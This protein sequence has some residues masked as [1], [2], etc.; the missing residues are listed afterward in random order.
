MIFVAF[1]FFVNKTHTTQMTIDDDDEES[2]VRMSFEQV[3]GLSEQQQRQQQQ[4][5]AHSPTLVSTLLT[6]KQRLHRFLEY[7]HSSWAATIWAYFVLTIILISVVF[8]I[9]ESFPQFYYLSLWW[10]AETVV[11]AFFTIEYALRLFASS[12]NIRDVWNFVRQPMNIIDFLSFAPFYV[13]ILFALASFALHITVNVPIFKVMRL[14]RVFRLVRIAQVQILL[15]AMRKSLDMLASVLFFICLNILIA[16]TL[17]YFAERGQ[18][19][20]QKKIFV[21]KDG[22]PT[23]FQSILISA[24]WSVVT[25]TTTGYGDMIPQT[26]IGKAIAG[27]SI[28]IGVLVIALPSLL[29]GSA[30]SELNNQY[31]LKKKRER[32][33]AEREALMNSNDELRI[34]QSQESELTKMLRKHNRVLKEQTQQMHRA[35][36]QAEATQKLIS[37]LLNKYVVD[38]NND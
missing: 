34:Q 22:Q 20:Y 8:M 3:L 23:Q 12:N 35:I 25:M 17:I 1:A 10:Y 4:Q 26:S 33:Q 14:F 31:K 32:K 19:D 6:F 21:G 13:E 29:I 2:E 11:V 15:S 37:E 24:Y 18:Y 38:E 5:Y 28:L 27:A 36:E 16:S 30:F 9:F 7:P